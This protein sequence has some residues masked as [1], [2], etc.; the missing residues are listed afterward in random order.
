MKKQALY[1]GCL[2]GLLTTGAAL[3]QDPAP[4]AAP[5]G[6]DTRIATVNGTEV[7]LDLFRLYFAERAR[8]STQANTPEF[9]NQV[10]N[11]FLNIMVTAQDAERQKLADQPGVK[12]ALELQR[13]QLMSRLALQEKAETLAPGEDALKKAYEER[14]AKG[15]RTEYKA[16]H[17]LV[18]TKDEAEQVI[19]DLQKGAKFDELAKTKSEGPTGKSGGDLGWFDATQMVPPFATAVAAMKPGEYSKEPVQT[20]FGWHVI[21]LEETRQAQPPALS[22]VKDELTA[23]VQREGLANYVAELRNNAKIDLNADLIKTNSGPGATPAP[24]K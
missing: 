15:D 8:Q 18:K 19:K 2:V 5:P 10:F 24:A 7:P 1:I 22:D 17:I 14:Y 21:Q 13:M 23:E 16:R 12:Y 6:G 4:A 20:Q 9:Q 3:S 11:E